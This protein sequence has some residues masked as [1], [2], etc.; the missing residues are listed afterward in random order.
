M[1]ASNPSTT[2]YTLGRGIV[3]IGAWS[4]VS[5]PGALSD[6]GNSPRFEAEVT[7]ELLDHFSSRSGTRDKDKQ[8]TLETGFTINFDL[9]EFSVSN[10]AMFLKGSISGN[11]ISANVELDKE[12]SVKFVS[13]N[14]AGP[15]ESWEFHRVKLSPGGSLNLISDEWGLMTFSGE[16][17]SDSANNP[18]SPYFTVTFATTTTTT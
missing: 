14:P 12:Y 7:E 5:P 3:S 17:L 13:D 9:D 2:L 10:L 8:V 18:T 1:P 4:G 6:V 11:V 15:N 16:G